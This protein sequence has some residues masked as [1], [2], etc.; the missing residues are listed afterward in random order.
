MNPYYYLYYKIYVFTKK[1]GNYQ[2]AFGAVLA[3]TFLLMQN[4]TLLTIIFDDCII[5]NG[6]YLIYFFGA[7]MM[8]INYLIIKINTKK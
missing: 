8:V 6:I 1:T 5:F 3:L 2:V 4:L 7:V